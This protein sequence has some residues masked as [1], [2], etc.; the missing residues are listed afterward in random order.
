LVG[1]S[2]PLG[3]WVR[4]ER[5]KVLNHRGSNGTGPLKPEDWD[6]AV[7]AEPVGKD[8]CAIHH[9]NRHD[10]RYYFQITLLVCI[11]RCVRDPVPPTQLSD[12]RT[13]FGLFQNR[14]EVG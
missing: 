13:I 4:H 8:E 1:R 10:N 5:Y 6:G 7:F 2:F 14:D 3:E 12:L 11:E 9:E